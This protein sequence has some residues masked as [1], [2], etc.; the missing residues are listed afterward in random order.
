ML[1]LS[2]TTVEVY[3]PQNIFICESCG[4]KGNTYSTKVGEYICFEC[5]KNSQRGPVCNYVRNREV[6]VNSSFNLNTIPLI[7]HNLEDQRYVYVAQN[8]PLLN[9]IKDGPNSIRNRIIF[10]ELEIDHTPFRVRYSRDAYDTL[11]CFAPQT[12]FG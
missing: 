5:L 2:H 11:C 6:G 3:R 12:V 9:Q 10:Q 4:E 1:D 8:H 7:F